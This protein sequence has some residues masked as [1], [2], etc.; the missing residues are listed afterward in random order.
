MRQYPGFLRQLHEQL[1]SLPASSLDRI[2]RVGGFEVSSHINA[3][4]N[5]SDYTVCD[6]SLPLLEPP[7]QSMDDERTRL[8]GHETIIAG[9]AG[10]CIDAGSIDKHGALVC[11]RNIMAPDFTATP[12]SLLLNRSRQFRHV[13]IIVP[14]QFV[15]D[16]KS[17]ISQLS[18]TAHVK[19]LP[20]HE[21]MNL[22]SVNLLQTRGVD[23]ELS[24]GGPGDVIPILSEFG[25][26]T[27]FLNV[28]GRHICI[29]DCANLLANIDDAILGQHVN[30]RHAVTCQVTTL[31]GETNCSVICDHMGQ[32]QVVESFKLDFGSGSPNFSL[33]STGTFIVSAELDFSMI[34]WQWHRRKV[35]R[36]GAVTVIFQRYMDDLTRVFKTQFIETVRSL[37]Y[38]NIE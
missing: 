5:P 19:V 7:P 35:M 27:S 9:R 20:H 4:L 16:V 26:I 24:S 22:S 1:E 29:V 8:V 33:R 32:R 17:Y 6:P 23:A 38:R 25:E 2:N 10:L 36:E 3:I 28:G 15:D 30:S 18:Y 12:L 11:L 13:W 37:S 21:V 31:Q 34:D 14:R